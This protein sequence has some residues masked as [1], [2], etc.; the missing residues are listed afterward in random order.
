MSKSSHTKVDDV[1]FEAVLDRSHFPDG[2]KELARVLAEAAEVL[3]MIR[4]QPD[5][6]L[7]VIA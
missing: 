7:P 5:S 4:Q 1:S 6:S 3:R 2:S